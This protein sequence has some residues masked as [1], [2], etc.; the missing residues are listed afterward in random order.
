MHDSISI[1]TLGF[2]DEGMP[3]SYPPYPP[4]RTAPNGR[5]PGRSTL[6]L[7]DGPTDE[8]NPGSH[9]GYQSHH[10]S[11]RSCPPRRS[12]AESMPLLAS[13]PALTEAI[14]R[15]IGRTYRKRSGRTRRTRGVI[16]HALVASRAGRPTTAEQD[17]LSVLS[18]VERSAVRTR[19][20]KRLH[21]NSLR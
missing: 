3:S 1:Q 4:Y 2:G 15:L 20:E 7:Q 9:P 16:L 5:D 6:S 21:R 18:R 11:P 12:A 17:M 19:A 8:K 10:Y 14:Q 13:G